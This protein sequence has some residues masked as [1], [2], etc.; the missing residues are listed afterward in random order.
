MV[1]P[2]EQCFLFSWTNL[3]MFL[4]PLFFCIQVNRSQELG[5]E[6][7]NLLQA[8]ITL[9]KQQD[10]LDRANI[11]HNPSSE[12]LGRARDIAK[13]MSTPKIKV[14]TTCMNRIGTNSNH[15]KS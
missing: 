11:L 14:S 3:T 7:L 2:V 4:I 12:E 9:Q 13:R 15:N 10:N 5:M 6:L 1:G 8:R